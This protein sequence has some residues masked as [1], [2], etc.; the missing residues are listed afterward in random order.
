MP[1]P[2]IIIAN[3]DIQDSQW[4]DHL[5]EKK[6][7]AI[8]AVDGGANHLLFRNIIPDI[9][10]GDLDSLSAAYV[11]QL[12]NNWVN[13][14]RFDPEKDETDLELALLYAAEQTAWSQAPIY[15]YAALGGRLDHEIANLML[16]TH[17]KLIERDIQLMAPYQNT[18]LITSKKGVMEIHGRAGDTISL[19]P[20]KGDAQIAMTE[21]LKWP[22][23]NSTLRFGPA[24]GVSNEMTGSNCKISV[25]SG[26]VLCI[27]I[28]NHWER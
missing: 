22:L 23:I 11:E 16:L 8:I 20:L 4:S 28:D 9:V 5:L 10:I 21:N 17:P 3:G 6:A 12:E 19:I 15:V 25:E 1:K 27:H 7:Q 18:F 24:R 26:T 2:V 13:I 14:F